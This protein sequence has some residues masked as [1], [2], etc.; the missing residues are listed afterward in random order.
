MINVRMTASYFD[1]GVVFK[2]KRLFILNIYQKYP[3]DN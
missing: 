3:P 2:I 1:F